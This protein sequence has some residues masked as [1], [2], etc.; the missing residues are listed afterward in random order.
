MNNNCDFPQM[1]QNPVGNVEVDKI[2]QLEYPLHSNKTVE[3]G[4]VAPT[5][6][7][8][9]ITKNGKELKAPTIIV[10]SDK[11]IYEK[12]VM[13]NGI[14]GL[15]KKAKEWADGYYD[16]LQYN[17]KDTP[18]L[19]INELGLVGASFIPY[20][21]IKSYAPPSAGTSED[22]CLQLEVVYF[23]IKQLKKPNGKLWLINL[24]MGF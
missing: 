7:G 20:D 9:T 22:S 10:S 14:K 13:F 11:P 8:D 15:R 3:G 19:A 6:Y 17:T 23:S 16:F 21:P 18:S 24:W 12:A 2:T 5:I 4:K 1:P